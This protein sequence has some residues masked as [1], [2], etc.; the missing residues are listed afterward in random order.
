MISLERRDV[1][2]KVAVGQIE[3]LFEG[4]EL[5]LVVHHQDRHEREPDAVLKD[6]VDIFQNGF[7]F[8][9]FAYIMTP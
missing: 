8:S 3:H 2:G 6:L 7:H 1:R 4:V 5:G 9:Y